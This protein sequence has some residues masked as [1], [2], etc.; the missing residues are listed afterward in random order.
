LYIVI[1]SD[2][3]VTGVRTDETEAVMALVKPRKTDADQVVADLL[4]RRPE[5]DDNAKAL[6][7]LGKLLKQYEDRY[8]LPSDRLHAAVES[9]EL[10]ES[11]DVCDWLIHYAIFLRVQ[12][13]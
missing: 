3:R 2:R 5:A 10:T 6:D 13:R 7:E 8:D 9:G 12:A 1:N 11:L 4:A